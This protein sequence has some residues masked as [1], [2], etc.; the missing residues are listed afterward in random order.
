MDKNN[1]TENINNIDTYT[2]KQ[3]TRS[4]K[5]SYLISVDFKKEDISGS[6]FHN[7]ALNHILDIENCIELLEDILIY[8]KPQRDYSAILNKIKNRK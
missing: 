2:I 7:G 4:A 1:E 8:S 3:G 6:C 5:T